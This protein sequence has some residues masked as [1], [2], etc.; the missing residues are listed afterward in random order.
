MIKDYILIL[1]SSDGDVRAD[2][3]KIESFNLLLHIRDLAFYR[4]RAPEKNILL[5]R[6]RGIHIYEIT[7]ENIVYDIMSEDMN[8]E[9]NDGKIYLR[10]KYNEYL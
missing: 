5:L 4:I 3:Y 10:P 6:L 9:F 2:D 1:K 8:I 7:S